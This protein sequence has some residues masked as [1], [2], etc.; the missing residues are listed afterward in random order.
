[1]NGKHTEHCAATDREK[2]KVV[3]PHR[4]TTKCKDTLSY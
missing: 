4:H 1:M 3:I 2:N